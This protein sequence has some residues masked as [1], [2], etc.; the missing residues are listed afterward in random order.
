M[1]NLKVRAYMPASCIGDYMQS[2]AARTF[3]LKIILF[4]KIIDYQAGNYLRTQ[5]ARVIIITSLFV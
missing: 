1:Y 2:I 5:C 4:N 3:L